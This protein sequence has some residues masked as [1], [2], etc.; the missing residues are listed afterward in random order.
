MAATI[1]DALCT[2]KQ[3]AN[4]R[5]LASQ[6]SCVS[7]VS[8]GPLWVPVVSSHLL[9]I[10]LWY[11]P[12][13]LGRQVPLADEHCC[14]PLAPRAGKSVILCSEAVPAADAGTFSSCWIT[15]ELFV[16]AIRILVLL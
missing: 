2:S 12:M 7:T 3:L 9:L 14:R 13:Q 1:W 15:F 5:F 6:Q 4:P 16:A 8:T 11:G 10:F